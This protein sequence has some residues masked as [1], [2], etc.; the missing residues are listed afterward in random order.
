MRRS[1]RGMRQLQG[2]LLLA[3]LVFAPAAAGA[4]EG[5]TEVGLARTKA[6]STRVEFGA[7]PLSATGPTTA[8]SVG[9]FG[10][11]LHGSVGLTFPLGTAVRLGPSV[12]WDSAW[13]SQRN[14][15]GTGFGTGGVFGA[16]GAVLTAPLGGDFVLAGKLGVGGALFGAGGSLG[17]SV[18]LSLAQALPFVRGHTI[19]GNL[20]VQ[21]WPVLF[22]PDLD[23]A[24]FG[25]AWVL[26]LGILTST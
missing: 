2:V 21:A 3:L 11:A 26:S 8:G 6:L 23:A 22:S 5:S 13:A 18:G 4:S 16:I 1:H 25:S 12:D 20:S 19:G 9:L 15:D 10:L 24:N 17:P 14:E 7:G